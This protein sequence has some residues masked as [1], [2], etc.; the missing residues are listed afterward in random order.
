LTGDPCCLTDIDVAILAGGLGTR[1]RPVLGETPKILA[2]IAGRPFLDHIVGWLERFGARRIVLLLGHGSAQIGT[3]LEAR[4][5]RAQIE[6]CVEPKPLGTAG[7]I[8]LARPSLRSDPVIVMNGDSFIDAD[9]CALVER[10][11]HD[12]RSG[13]ILCAEVPNTARFGRIE[14]DDAGRIVRFLEKD[15]SRRQPGL[16]SAG[17]YCLGHALLDE[18]ARGTTRSFEHE[19]LERAPPGSFGAVV[20]G[21]RFIDIGTPGDF[22]AAERLL[23][24]IARRHS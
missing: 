2:P 13:A 20:G 24:D 16:I 8:R 3:Y 17:V 11:Q 21:S 19:V 1:I 7:A 14:V 4:S 18:V 12:G 6:T 23:A 15:E 5:F 22:A 9:L 10:H